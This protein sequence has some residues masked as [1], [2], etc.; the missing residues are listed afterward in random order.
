MAPTAVTTIDL[1][2]AG[3]K[4]S[5]S[6]LVVNV[7][8]V[9]VLPS[10][11]GQAELAADAGPADTAGMAATDMATA[12]LK[13]ARRAKA[14]T[15]D[16]PCPTFLDLGCVSVPLATARRESIRAPNRM[17][18]SYALVMSAVRA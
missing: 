2:P 16:I 18:A 5:S 9:A 8:E 14:G 6:P 7:H 17:V 12:R 4:N 15:W 13:P 10:A 11:V 3:T 1:T